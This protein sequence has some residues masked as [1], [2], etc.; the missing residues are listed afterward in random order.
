MVI[1]AGSHDLSAKYGGLSTN[2]HAIDVIMD[3]KEL[4]I[5]GE[6]VDSTASRFAYELQ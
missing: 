1:R 3:D 4:F 6:C 2:D 5:A